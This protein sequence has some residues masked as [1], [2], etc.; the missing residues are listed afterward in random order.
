MTDGAS[1]D[2]T[3]AI[4]TGSDCLHDSHSVTADPFGDWLAENSRWDSVGKFLIEERG[5]CEHGIDCADGVPACSECERQA[6]E[7]HPA[8][9][10][11]EGRR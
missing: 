4:C 7:V 2:N 9:P 3:G 6:R 10:V 11:R 8:C 1:R 5:R